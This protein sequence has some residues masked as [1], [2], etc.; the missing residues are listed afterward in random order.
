MLASLLPPAVRVKLPTVVAPAT[1]KPV[2]AVHD[3]PIRGV[4]LQ[5]SRTTAFASVA[6]VNVTVYVTPVASLE[7][8]LSST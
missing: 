8:L 3:A 2:G 7:E 6:G 1:V 4:S 5:K